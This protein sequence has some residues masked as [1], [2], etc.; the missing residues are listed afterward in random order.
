MA[1]TQKPRLF[2]ILAE[3]AGSP[4]T[5]VP[6]DLMAP[7]EAQALKNHT[8][9]L[10]RL[11]QRGGLD[12]AEAVAVLEGRDPLPLLPFAEAQ[13]RLAEIVAERSAVLPT[14]D[15]AYMLVP[16]CDA[17]AWW[18]PFADELQ[19]GKVGGIVGRLSEAAPDASELLDGVSRVRLGTCELFDRCGQDG[20]QLDAACAV[21]TSADFGCVQWKARA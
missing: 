7:H 10:D 11:A 3:R 12:P 19:P 8:Q 4:K 13:Y 16:R 18:A 20:A 14:P 2:P 21:S 9:T 5:Y 6:W 15:A 1:T 17:C